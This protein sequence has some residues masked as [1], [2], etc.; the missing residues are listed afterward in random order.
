MQYMRQQPLIV[1]TFVEDM[2]KNIQK[3]TGIEKSKQQIYVAEIRMRLNRSDPAAVFS[4]G[5]SVVTFSNSS[6]STLY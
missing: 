2:T 1:L 4:R 5:S 6:V 3:P